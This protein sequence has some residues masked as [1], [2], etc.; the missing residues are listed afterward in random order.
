MMASSL[1]SLCCLPVNLLPLKRDT[2]TLPL[3]HI[4]FCSFM[5]YLITR[6]VAIKKFEKTVIRRKYKHK[7]V[8]WPALGVVASSK[9]KP[10]VL[11]LDVWT[12]VLV[13]EKRESA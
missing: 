12:V 11:V 4:V 1:E 10:V 13:V 6:I 8:S 3:L 9:A 7:G 2:S 5:F